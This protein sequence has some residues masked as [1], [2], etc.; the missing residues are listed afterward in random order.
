MK[1][2]TQKETISETQKFSEAGEP[3]PIMTNPPDN[4]TVVTDP[5]P[6]RKNVRP[7]AVAATPE[8][9]EEKAA[10]FTPSEAN[11][12]R[13]RW[14]SV[15]VGFVDEPRQ[16]VEEADELVSLTTKRVAEMFAEQRKKLEQVWDRGD[17][18]STE[19]LRVALRRYRSFFLRLLSF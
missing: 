18:V 5:L 9:Q 15:Q 10:L 19:D 6:E 16:T 17:E 2:F 12:L 8:R 11:E 13:A 14:E 7:A 3:Q 1:E 4:L